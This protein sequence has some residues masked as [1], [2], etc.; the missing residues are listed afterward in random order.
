MPDSVFHG[1]FVNDAG[2]LETTLLIKGVVSA[3]VIIAVI[4]PI[5]IS[6]FNKKDVS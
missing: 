4:T 5:T 6:I 2:D 3:A 1:N